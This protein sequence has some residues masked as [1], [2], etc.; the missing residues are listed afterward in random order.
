MIISNFQII[1]SEMVG[2]EIVLGG[3]VN[4]IR[5][6]G[7]LLFIDLRSSTDAI[8]C[9]I[10]PS[11]QNV[12][13]KLQNI[14]E[15]YVLKITGEVSKR[16][17]ET[18]NTNIWAGDI[19]ILINDAEIVA[20]ANVPPFPIHA[21]DE[22]LAGE[23]IRLKYR[24]LDIRRSKMQNI[25]KLRSRM[26]LETRNWFAI[27][28]FMEVQTPVLAN[29]SP[30]GARDFLVPSRV[31]PGKFYALPQAPQQFKQLLMVGGVTKYLQIS[32][33]FRDEDPRADRLYG[34]FTQIDAEIAWATRA[35]IKELSWRLIKEVFAKYSEFEL[36]DGFVSITYNDAM[37]RYGSDK[38]DLRTDIFWE[39][40]AD[41]FLESDFDAFSTIAKTVGGRVK[42]ILIK[43]ASSKMSRSDLD[44]VQDI[45]RSYGLPGIAYI[46]YNEDGAKSPIFKLLGV[47][48]EKIEHSITE[49][50]GATTGDLV[51]FLAHEKAEELYK[52]QNAIRIHLARYMGLIDDKTLQCVWIDSM[53]F[54]ERGA[55]GKIEFGHNPF[56]VW[57]GGLEVL[58]E[59]EARGEDALLALKAEQYDIAINGYELLS[60]GVRNQD[61]E[62]L[63]AVFRICGYSEEEVTEKFGHMIEAYSYGAPYHAGFAWGVERLIMVLI[64]E[65]NIREVDAFPTNGSGIST[66]MNYPSAPR[67]GQLKEL[68]IEEIN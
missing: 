49:R 31:H 50:L 14:R 27:E 10:S 11:T 43:G 33:C 47:N 36:K 60:G 57:P 22:Q 16:S 23:D 3:F 32:P 58:K 29:S 30:E 19:E 41:L 4:K 17:A 54:F 42:A 7:G 59:A 37:E 63:K 39:N 13:E 65:D 62:S 55:S 26:L 44:K 61:P 6:H 51:L 40:V 18:I 34:G 28:G 1:T 5:D 56:S 66:M 15:E 12:F 68:H 53:P 48:A 46:Q 35:D 8:Q 38:P 67:A 24:Y 25:L 20:T 64:G 2:K 52:A 9:V 45:G 21:S